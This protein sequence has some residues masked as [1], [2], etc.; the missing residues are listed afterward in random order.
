MHHT[1]EEGTDLFEGAL[2]EKVDEEYLGDDEEIGS[3]DL[4][5]HPQL[6]RLDQVPQFIDYMNNQDPSF[7]RDHSTSWREGGGA[8]GHGGRGGRGG[9]RGRGR[10]RGR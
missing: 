10:G 5:T 1:E 7:N 6:L 3:D 2:G 4:E 9:F 8:E